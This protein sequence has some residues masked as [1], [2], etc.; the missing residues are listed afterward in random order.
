M[1]FRFSW[2]ASTAGK[3]N[4]R[5]AASIRMMFLLG[6][7]GGI[8]PGASYRTA[9]IVGAQH[10][11]VINTVIVNKSHERGVRQAGN[12]RAEHRLLELCRTCPR[13]P[14][15]PSLTLPA[16]RLPAHVGRGIVVHQ[17]LSRSCRHVR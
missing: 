17:F 16:R 7:A 6:W 13:R 10:A 3:A 1:T 15:L 8:G 9:W 12:R 14:K 4:K 5:A 11:A 2:A